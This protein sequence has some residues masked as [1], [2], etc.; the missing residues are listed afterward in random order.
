MDIEVHTVVTSHHYVDYPA[1][2]HLRKKPYAKRHLCTSAALLLEEWST[3]DPEIVQKKPRF[4]HI[5]NDILDTLIN[6]ITTV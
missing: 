3:F 1:K 5:M 6:D 2:R 4:C